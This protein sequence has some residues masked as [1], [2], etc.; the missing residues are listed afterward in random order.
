VDSLLERRPDTTS[1]LGDDVPGIDDEKRTRMF[2]RLSAA[3]VARIATHAKRRTVASGEILYDQ[4]AP[5][6]GIYVVLSGSLE[7][8]R[9]GIAGDDKVTVHTAGQFTG[10]VSSLSGRPSLTRGRAREA[11]ELLVLDGDALRRVIQSDPD[12]SDVLMRAFILRR[13]M[14]LS[15]GFGDATLLGSK[16]S[17]GTLGIQEFFTR[18]G[19]PYA[20]IDIDEDKDVQALLDR[21]H[22]G[23]GDVPVVICR[24]EAVLK[25]PT[26]EA[27][28]KCLGM[29][30]ALDPHVTHDVVV[31]GGGPAGL[32]AAVYGASEGLDVLVLESNAPGG[33]AGTSS[34]IENY[35]GF[36]TGVSGQ[37]LARRAIA[38]AQKFGTNIAIAM[39]AVEFLCEGNAGY[40]VNL[41]NGSRVHA[42]AVII[43]SGVRYRRL[44]LADLARFEGV[45]IYYGATALE[46]NLCRG[47][48]VVVVGGANSAGQAAVF[49]SSQCSHV[50]VLVRGPGLAA[51]M[52]RYLIRRIEETPNITLSPYS[53]VVGLEGDDRLRVVR[54]RKKDGTIVEREIEHAFLMIG[55]DPNSRWLQGCVAL[56]ERGFVKT[57]PDLSREEL[58]HA[59]WP[60]TR[61]PLLLETNRPRVFAVGDVRSGSVKRVASAVGEGSICVQLVHRALAK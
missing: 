26:K 34:K 35:L 52:S 50:H 28:A 13:V 22:V 54:W 42:R 38:Q 44:D 14:L 2:P 19:H 37:D 4:G 36:P 46:A 57:G 21:F 7:A 12:L 59:R 61:A 3:Q 18:N 49:L 16:H 55:A 32:A 30:A 11:G 15:S 8:V 48:E 56:D 43:A 47:E 5:D 31:V 58:A 27:V 33:Q 53:E 17:A 40:A 24:G 45:G 23:V 10:E 41:T 20:Y 1:N 6:A 29:N 39:T 9:P 25:N 60:L 51:T